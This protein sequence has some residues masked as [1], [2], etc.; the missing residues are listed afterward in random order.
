MGIL[1]FYL[2]RILFSFVQETHRTGQHTIEFNDSLL[3]GWK[4]INSGFQN[5]SSAGVGLIISPQSE[6]IDINV[7]MEGRI[8][9]VK[10]IIKGIK[11]AAI[12]AYSPTEVYADASK[13][14]FH[15]NLSKAIKLIKSTSPTFKLLI[16]ADMNATIG[17][18]SEGNWDCIGNNNDIL[19]TNDNGLR[20][21]NVCQEFQL[22]ILNTLFETRKDTKQVY[23]YSTP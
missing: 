20:L 1:N 14:N 6:I 4:F 5:K 3:N 9:V 15:N 22:H 16:G 21:L 7:V 13:D 17:K 18:D 11:L 23:Y 19:P 2:K 8:L 12:C 10:I